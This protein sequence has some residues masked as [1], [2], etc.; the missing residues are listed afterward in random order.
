MDV[1]PPSF[2]LE[3]EEEAA[4]RAEADALFGEE[5]I[6]SVPRAHCGQCG[7]FVREA[8]VRKL[9]A[10]RWEDEDVWRGTCS[11]HGEDVDVVWPEG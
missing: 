7:R 11:E 9:P 1:T 2:R 3:T 4:A 8:S 6:H 5:L 10:Y